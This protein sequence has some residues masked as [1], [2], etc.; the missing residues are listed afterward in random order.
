[1]INLASSE[2]FKTLNLKG[3][4]TRVIH[5]EFYQLKDDRLK[6]IVIYTKKA[7]G[8]M[9][10]YIIENKIE[11]PEDLKGFSAEGY[12]FSPQHSTEHLFVFTR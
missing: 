7:R 11:D 2:Y 6:Q 12:W 10:R 1:L 9:A 4:K 3:T 8:L 5:I